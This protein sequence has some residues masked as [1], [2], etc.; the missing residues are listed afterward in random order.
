MNAYSLQECATSGDG[1]GR[2]HQKMTRMSKTPNVRNLC[3]HELARKV[4]CHPKR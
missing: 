4:L 2:A 3:I 1:D